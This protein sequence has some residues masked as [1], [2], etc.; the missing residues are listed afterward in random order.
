M[1]AY[2]IVQQT[3]RDAAKLEEYRAKVGPILAKHGGRFLTKS[4][5]HKL[6]VGMQTMPDRVAIVE[7]PDMAALN[8]WYNSAEYQPLIALRQSAVDR[9]TEVL[10]TLEGA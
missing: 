2:L 9:H 10:I 8:T 6:L 1:A 4:G 3:V 5:S 7:F